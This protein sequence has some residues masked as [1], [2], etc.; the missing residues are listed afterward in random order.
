MTKKTSMSQTA[1]KNISLIREIRDKGFSFAAIAE[2]L[3]GKGIIVN[4][5]AVNK[6]YN[7]FL[8]RSNDKNLSK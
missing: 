7:N 8:R 4:S 3:R 1:E 5:I 6:A 2:I